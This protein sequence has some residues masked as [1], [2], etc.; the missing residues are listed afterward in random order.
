[1]L[2]YRKAPGDVLAV[3]E[4]RDKDKYALQRCVAEL[5]RLVQYDP[6]VREAM[7]RDELVPRL[8]TSM[9]HHATDPDL[10]LQLCV[11]LQTVVIYDEKSTAEFQSAIVKTGLWRLMLDAMRRDEALVSPLQV[12]GCKL[13]SILCYDYPGAPHEENQNEMA[14]AGI[15][16][17][18]VG[19]IE[20]DA[21]LPSTYVIAVQVLADLCYKNAANVD[22]VISLDI[23]GL[24]THGLHA[25]ANNLA[26]VQGI[27]TA[28]FFM[29]VA[30][31][32]AAK[33][34]MLQCKV[35]ERLLQC[36]NSPSSDIDTSYYLLRLIEVMLRKNGESFYPSPLP[37][38]GLEPAKDLFC[39]LN[40][41]VGLVAT[42]ERLRD[43][44]KESMAHLVYIAAIIFSSLTLQLPSGDVET[45]AGRI[46]PH[47]ER[48]Q[49][50]LKDAIHLFAT[51]SLTNF[52]KETYVLEQ[53]IC[54]IERL[55]IT[56]PNRLL[57]VRAGATRHMR[58]I[59]NTKQHEGLLELC[60]RVMCTLDK[61]T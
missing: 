36:L 16:D 43:K 7:A 15:L 17:V 38:R 51:S 35:L 22:R 20:C 29:V 27:S 61:E 25:H 48:T 12:E 53:C 45:T 33:A 47:V 5:S 31:P 1:M 59:Y 28:F 18:V 9:H 14:T 50:L 13:T 55:V 30:N 42:L 39:S 21:P 3:L 54:L 40:G 58:Y 37:S 23:M 57:L 8:A 19:L 4:Q 10:L 34:S 6:T 24:L 26:I 52:P 41:P 60:E 49:R 11:F 44:R 56:N 2:F 46:V 32:E